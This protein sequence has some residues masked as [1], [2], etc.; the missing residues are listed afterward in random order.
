[1]RQQWNGDLLQGKTSQK[2]YL[3]PLS[4]QPQNLALFGPIKTWWIIQ[5]RK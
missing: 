2:E 4:G 5:N 1:M 3:L